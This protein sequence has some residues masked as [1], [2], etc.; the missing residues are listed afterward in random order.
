MAKTNWSTSEFLELET[1]INVRTATFTLAWLGGVTIVDPNVKTTNCQNLSMSG[2]MQLSG[3][4][5]RQGLVQAL[6][7]V[8]V[9]VVCQTVLQL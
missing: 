7:V 2:G 5:V 3:R 8:E 6:M 4:A 9:K 1:A